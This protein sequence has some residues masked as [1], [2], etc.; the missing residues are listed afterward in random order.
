[1]TGATKL[2]IQQMIPI[3][4]AVLM[5][6]FAAAVGKTIYVDN[7]ASEANDGSSWRLL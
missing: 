3:W 1:M 5:M 7:D 2:R 4:A 6:P